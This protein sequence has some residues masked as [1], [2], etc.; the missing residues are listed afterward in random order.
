MKGRPVSCCFTG[1]RPGKLPWGMR[2]DDPRCVALK[3]E[4]HT[5]VCSAM[6]QGYTHFLC[7]MAQGCDLYFAEEILFQKTV[8]PEITLEAVIPCLTQADQ[9]TEPERERYARIL[10]AADLET[11][12]QRT[13]SP[14]CMQRRN[15]YMVDHSAMLIAAHGG[16]SGG[17]RST[18]LY[19]MK[20][21]L[22]IVDIPIIE[23][24]IIT[25]GI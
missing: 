16:I 25:A 18:V 20:C 12:I 8:D 15:R 10:A 1:H 23:K 2:E 3:Q 19:A 9:W 7:G 6:E 14:G 22:E 4:I 17:A 13:Y 5:A 21:G 24:T 11:V